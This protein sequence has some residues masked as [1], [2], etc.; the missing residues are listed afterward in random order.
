MRGQAERWLAD[1]ARNDSWRREQHE[2]GVDAARVCP[3]DTG[4]YRIATDQREERGKGGLWPRGAD[5]NHTG[6]LRQAT[7]RQARLS[8]FTGFSALPSRGEG[9]RRAPSLPPLSRPPFPAPPCASLRAAHDRELPGPARSP[10]PD[11]DDRFVTRPPG[12]TATPGPRPPPCRES[13]PRARR[14]I[15]SPRERG[16]RPARS[17]RPAASARR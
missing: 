14:T 6:S 7:T 1:D 9:R 2:F 5:E 16:P 15:P 3:R 12:V 13:G 10:Y 4:A 17:S 8:P 11:A